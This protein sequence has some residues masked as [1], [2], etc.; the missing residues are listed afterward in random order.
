MSDEELKGWLKSIHA[1]VQAT[2]EKVQ[3]HQTRVSLLEEWQRRITLNIR[4]VWAAIVTAVVTGKLH[5]K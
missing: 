5:L 2:L 1:D 3:A 4:V